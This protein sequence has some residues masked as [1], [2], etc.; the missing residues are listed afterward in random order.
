MLERILVVD[1]DVRLTT[2][3]EATLKEAGYAPMVAHTAEDGLRLAITREPDLVLLDVMMPN[4][5]GWELCR[6]LRDFSEMPIIFLTALSDVNDIVR[7]LEIGA[8]DYL[9]K[10][11][12]RP[13]LLA[14]IKAHLRRT[15]ENKVPPELVFGEGEFVID[16]MRRGVEI[17]GK[18]VEL[19]PREFDLLAT[20]ARHA[21]RVLTKEE[22][23]RQAWGLEDEDAQ[24][25]LKPYIHYLRKKIEEDSA[26]PR[27]ILTARGVGYRFAD[28]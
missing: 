10:P 23:L 7:G 15:P 11:F 19:T 8:D 2:T 1:D 22:L 18:T 5:G 20:L 17:H 16:L 12:K 26:S 21:G 9:V 27:W 24:D 13:E 3:I 28:A 25:N 4:M 6:R 14:R